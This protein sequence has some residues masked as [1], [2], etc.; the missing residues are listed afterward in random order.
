M[1]APQPQ[2]DLGQPAGRPPITRASATS[3]DASAL[4][5]LLTEATRRCSDPSGRRMDRDGLCWLACEYE[6][7]QGIVTLHSG[8]G[9][10]RAGRACEAIEPVKIKR[11]AMTTGLNMQDSKLN[12]PAPQPEANISL[13]KIRSKRL[14]LSSLQFQLNVCREADSRKDGWA[15]LARLAVFIPAIDHVFLA[16]VLQ[17]VDARYLRE[18]TLRVSTGHDELVCCAGVTIPPRWSRL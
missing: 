14:T 4:L 1:A 10:V 9:L 15:A 16:E 7:S 17:D 12:G 6:K 2:N 5:T 8:T 13:A 11:D 18:D 3:V